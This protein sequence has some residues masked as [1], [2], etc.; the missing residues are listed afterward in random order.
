MR[1]GEF[2]LR[3]GTLGVERCVINGADVTDLVQDAWVVSRHAQPQ[4]AHLVLRPGVGPD[5]IKGDGVIEVEPASDGADV[6]RWLAGIDAEEVARIV[7]ERLSAVPM[8]AR[9]SPAAMVL[10]VLRD[11]AD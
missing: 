3:F 2:V 9:T 10:A 7:G 8:S 4:I 1:A 6:G 5:E 11:M